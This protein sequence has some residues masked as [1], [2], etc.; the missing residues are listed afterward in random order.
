MSASACGEANLKVASINVNG[1]RSQI[2]NGIS[3]RRKIFTWLK[4]LQIDVILLQETHSSLVDENIWVQ[5]WSG[6]GYF[7]HGE[8]N[9][10]GVGILIKPALGVSVSKVFADIDGRFIVLQLEYNGSCIT[11][12]NFYGP[13]IDNTRFIK[14]FCCKIDEYQ[15]STIILGG[16]FNLCLDIEK[17][18]QSLAKRVSNNEKCKDVLKQFMS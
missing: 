5:E 14:D 7:S 13:N 3:K 11:I 2:V 9:S 17:D 6:L 12:G 8:N 4:K 10:R 1:L 15:N 18:R 16:D